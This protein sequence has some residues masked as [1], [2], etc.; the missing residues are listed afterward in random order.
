MIEDRRRAR[1]EALIN[2]ARKHGAILTGTH[3]QL[4]KAYGVSIAG[5]AF[6]RDLHTVNA[7]RMFNCAIEDVTPAQRGAAKRQAYLETYTVVPE[8]T[9]K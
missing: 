5:V 8:K 4:A 1:V 7:S 3:E 6:A 2:W 9:S